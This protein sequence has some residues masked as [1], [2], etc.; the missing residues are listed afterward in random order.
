MSKFSNEEVTKLQELFRSEFG[1]KVSPEEACRYA[2][3]LLEIF[4]IVYKEGDHGKALLN[5]EQPP[6]EKKKGGQSR[7]G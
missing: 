1:L 7:S 2:W 5:P 3:Q 6:P 4:T